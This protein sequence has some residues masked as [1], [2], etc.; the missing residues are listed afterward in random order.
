M[1]TA[2]AGIPT[3]PSTEEL[4]YRARA[5]LQRCGVNPHNLTADAESITAGTAAKSTRTITVVWLAPHGDHSTSWWLA[6]GHLSNVAT[7]SIPI[8]VDAIVL[9]LI[10]SRL[11]I[12]VL[13]GSPPGPDLAAT[14]HRRRARHPLEIGPHLPPTTPGQCAV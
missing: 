12:P 8:T 10:K 13:H 9:A 6:P 4:V 2:H 5:A 11:I 7:A 1:T 14:N 3:T